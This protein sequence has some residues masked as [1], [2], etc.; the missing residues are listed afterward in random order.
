MKK[1]FFLK[2]I[3]FVNDSIW[4]YRYKVR[5][6]CLS[7]STCLWRNMQ[8]FHEFFPI[9]VHVTETVTG[10]GCP[11]LPCALPCPALTCRAN[12]VFEA[13]PVALQGKHDRAQ[14]RSGQKFLPW[15]F[16]FQKFLKEFSL[17]V[18]LTSSTIRTVAIKRC[19]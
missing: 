7:I 1:L 8:V 18:T 2:F 17:P 10:Q 14:G 11:D 6:P 3:D 9:V 15:Q 16:F 4:W 13:C 5:F 12:L 19:P